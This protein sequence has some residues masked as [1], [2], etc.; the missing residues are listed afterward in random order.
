MKIALIHDNLV[1]EGG[2]EKVLAALCEMFPESP[3][4][5]LVHNKNKTQSFWGNKEIRTSFLQKLPFGVSKFQWFLM[6]MPAATEKHDLSEFDL[7]ISSCSDFAKGVITKPTAKHICYCH[8]PTRYLWIESQKYVDTLRKNSLVKKFLPIALSKLRLW[9]RMAADRVDVFVAN[10]NVVA[11]RIKKYYGQDSRVIFP[12]V[13]T[14]KF[15]IS[16]RPKKYFLAGGRLVPYKR[17]DLAIT[18]FNRLNMP[19]KIFGDG[20]E[21]KNLMKLA[22]NNIEFL[23]KVSDSKKAELFADSKAFINPQEED[24]GITSIEAMASGRPVIAFRAGGAL[25]TVIDNETGI[26][27]DRQN[28]ED[29]AYRVLSFDEKSF[30][31]ET[32]RAHAQNF[33]LE[34]FR[35]KMKELISSQPLMD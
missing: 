20:S 33:D 17:F 21:K 2:A 24:F 35:N 15:F 32:I 1:Q 10:S 19:L 3:V 31:P 16:S 30:D 29:L 7:I 25:D 6:W 11:Q 27:F 28:W 4:F 26:F 5:T 8:T 22:K 13:E 9:D 34:I 12:P 14:S 18:A 23:G